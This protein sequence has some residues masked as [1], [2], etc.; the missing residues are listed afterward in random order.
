LA[1]EKKKG[2]RK[3]ISDRNMREKPPGGN[4]YGCRGRRGGGRGE[5]RDA[6]LSRK[7]RMPPP[8]TM[9]VEKEVYHSREGERRGKGV[10]SL[11]GC[12]IDEGKK[13]HRYTGERTRPLYC[14]WEAPG[15]EG[16]LRER[17]SL[18]S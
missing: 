17:E 1:I 12:R 7:K 9:P 6:S 13:T 15:E 8:R 4:R 16:S 2:K 10:I 3:A 11:L 18:A 5:G 14:F